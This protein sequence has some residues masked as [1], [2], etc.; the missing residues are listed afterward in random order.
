MCINVKSLVILTS[1]L[2]TEKRTLIAE[3]QWRKLGGD[4]SQSFEA[5]PA[6]EEGAKDISE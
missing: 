6:R 2:K 1:F 3:E 5:I 4:Q